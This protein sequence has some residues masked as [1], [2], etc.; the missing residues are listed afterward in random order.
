M[1]TARL[2]KEKMRG[3]EHSD[4]KKKAQK[5]VGKKKKKGKGGRKESM[6]QQSARIGGKLLLRR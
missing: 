6:E 5:Y 3:W 2:K 4:R 1:L